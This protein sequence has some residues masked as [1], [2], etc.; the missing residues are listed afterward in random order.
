MYRQLCTEFYNSDKY[1]ASIEEL[2][3]YYDLFK[4]EDLLFEPMCGSGRLLIPLIQSGYNVHGLDSSSYMLNSCKRRAAELNLEPLLY[5]G[6]VEDYPLN[7]QYH[8][9]IIPLG[10]FQLFY[11]RQKAYQALEKFKQF[12]VSGGKLVMDLFIP[13]EA[14]YEEG[15][16]DTS[17]RRVKLPTGELIEADNLT[18]AN[19]CQQHLLSKTRYTKYFEDKIVAV[20]DEQMDILWYYPFEMELMLEKY[21]F[22][23]VRRVDRF[24]NGGEHMTFIAKFYK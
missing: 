6:D 7:Q 12:L 21:G 18:T 11:P 3:L 8:G 10:S 5:Q 13:W 9:I 20:E 15:Q 14:M 19:K 16:V 4:K 22:K 1:F 23:E 24:L 2:Q 17:V